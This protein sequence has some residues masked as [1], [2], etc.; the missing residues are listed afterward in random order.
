MNRILKL[1]TVDKPIVLNKEMEQLVDKYVV[2]Y[3]TDLDMDFEL[4]KRN[5][6][7]NNR[8]NK[9]QTFIWFLRENG[10]V[11]MIE[12]F[13][14]V[15]N[16]PENIL[17]NYWKN[18]PIKA[19]RLTITKACKKN[20]YGCI[21][22]I[23]KKKY[24]DKILNSEKVCSNIE[25]ELVKKDKS[26]IILNETFDDYFYIKALN[27]NNIQTKDILSSNCIRYY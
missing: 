24:I 19:Y 25:F 15:K 6:N 14:N 8:K 21:E 12:D 27:K 20:I 26:T 10:T 23:N 9:N 4:I 2:N 17:F 1:G 18:E 7:T 5:K 13:I 11:L 3:K 16:S 22:S